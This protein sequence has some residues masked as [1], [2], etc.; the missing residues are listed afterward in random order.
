MSHLHEPS[1][2]TPLKFSM[3]RAPVGVYLSGTLDLRKLCRVIAQRTIL[4]ALAGF[5][6][7]TVENTLSLLDK[8]AKSIFTDASC[9]GKPVVENPFLLSEISLRIRLHYVIL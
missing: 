8:N 2:T 4:T 3:S 5:V 1:V 9:S 7:I 6:H